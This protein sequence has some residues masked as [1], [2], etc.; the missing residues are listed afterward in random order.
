MQYKDKY[1]LDDVRELEAWFETHRDRLPESIQLDAAIRIPDLH[2]MLEI[3]FENAVLHIENVTYD[4]A[5]YQLVR[6]RDRLL[7]MWADKSEA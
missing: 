7:E 1:T 2:R 5:I 6:L 4:P 3:Y